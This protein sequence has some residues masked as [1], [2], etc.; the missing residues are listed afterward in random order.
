[1]PIIQKWVISHSRI[2]N[3]ASL[4]FNRLLLYCLNNGFPLP[5]F[6]DQTLYIQCCNVGV[7][8]LRKEIPCLEYVWD[9]YFKQFPPID[10]CCNIQVYAYSAKQYSTNFKNALVSNFNH[11]QRSYIMQWCTEHKIDKIYVY[12][13]QC[14]INGWDVSSTLTEEMIQFA[15]GQRD[16]LQL[17]ID[18]VSIT[19]LKGHY[20]NIVR[21]YF[22]ILKYMEQFEYA[23]RFTLAPICDI[24]CHHLT[25]DTRI[26][27]AMM[28]QLVKCSNAK[29]FE[30]DRDIHFASAFTWKGLMSNKYTFSH[31][32]QT[33]G[34]SVCFHFKTTKVETINQ[35]KNYER[36][37]A[38]DP[39][40]SNL[41]F[42]VEEL[43]VGNI[44]TY[45]TYKLTRTIVLESIWHE[46]I[47]YS[48][49]EMGKANRR[50]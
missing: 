4:V 44:K 9:T 21:Y 28:S 48:S 13:I 25:I 41:M 46:N 5:N 23:K 34:V 36:T 1:M 49:C 26:L 3:K 22:T 31:L 47:Q 11:R 39:G 20:E 6:R 7:G 18:P 43:K 24:K 40:R 17:D 12:S 30:I 19:W 50:C 10:N 42:G 15:N 14:K 33:D 2:I 37:I 29:Q 27:R 32:I 16:I 45:K 8:E 35:P 38:I